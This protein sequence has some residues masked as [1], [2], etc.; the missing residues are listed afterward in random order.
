M[1][2]FP[3]LPFVLLG[4]TYA[5]LM[6]VHEFCLLPG[7]RAHFAAEGARGARKRQ[8]KFE[9]ACRQAMSYFYAVGSLGALREQLAGLAPQF[10]SAIAPLQVIA[11]VLGIFFVAVAWYR[12]EHAWEP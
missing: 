4:V 3:L 5:V 9:W 6:A 7:L 11:G 2:S 10:G 8:R 12:W 1:Y